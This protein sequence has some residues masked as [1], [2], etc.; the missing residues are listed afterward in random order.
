[1][2]EFISAI[3]FLNSNVVLFL[4]ISAIL[5]KKDKHI[6][7]YFLYVFSIASAIWSLGFAAFYVQTDPAQ[8]HVWRCFATFGTVLYVIV[9]QCL[10]A[11]ISRIQRKIRYIFDTIAFLG[12]P[13][14]L[15]SIRREQTSYFVS[16]FGMTYMFKP[17]LISN[18][19]FSYFAVVSLN[20]LITIVYM[21]RCSKGKRIKQF[22][23]HFLIVT[24]L[25]LVGT[26]L[27]MVLPV[28]G[29]GALPGSNITQ[30]WGIGVVYYAMNIIDKNEINVSNMSKYIYHSLGHPVMVFDAESRLQISNESADAFFDLNEEDKRNHVYCLGDLFSMEESF[31]GLTN[32]STLSVDAYTKTT[33]NPCNLT[34]S[35]IRDSY[36]DEIGYIVTVQDTSERMEYIESLKK[37]REEADS[38][39]QAKSRFLANMSHEIRT[40]MNAI[41]GFSEILLNQDMNP[42]QRERVGNIRNASRS[43]LAVIN[44]ILDISKIEAGRMELNEEDY[45]LRELI[46]DIVKQMQSLADNKGLEMEL[47]LADD[48]P[49]VVHGDHGKIREV[50]TN[51][52][53]NSIKYTN[54]GKVSLSVKA[55]ELEQNSQCHLMLQVEDTGI[56]V[57]EE[58]QELIFQAFEQSH[59]EK[60]IKT[61]GTG[62]G[63]SIVKG[64]IDLMGGT[65]ALKSQWGVGSVFTVELDQE[66][67]DDSNVG[68]E[69][70]NQLS[71]HQTSIGKLHIEGVQVL[72]VDDN[73][74]N[75]QVIRQSLEQY[76]LVVDTVSSGA[77]AIAK[78]REVQYPIIF[79]DQMMPE[80][81]GIQAMQAIRTLSAYYES[82]DSSKI[83]VLTANTIKGVREELLE[84][85]FDEYLKKPI[86]Y[87]HLEKT[88]CSFVPE[89]RITYIEIVEEDEKEEKQTDELRIPGVDVEEGLGHCGGKME[90][91]L[92]I[93]GLT[94]KNGYA[95]LAS[96]RERIPG[97]IDNYIIEI[98]GCK[99]MCYNIGAFSCGD[100]A[101]ELEMAAR[102]GQIDLILE[103]HPKFETLFTILLE[104]IASAI[105]ADDTS[106]DEDEETDFAYFVK[107]LKD[108]AQSYD[109]SKVERLVAKMAD[110]KW[111]GKEAEFLI[112]MKRL[113]DNV[114]FDGILYY[115]EKMENL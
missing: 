43:L 42:E 37:A 76:G 108:A 83:V 27:D 19:Y 56:G 87:K 95:Y 38:S 64:Y 89:D 105:G 97:D 75:L 81:D 84:K 47:N 17:G 44:Q 71:S 109:Y 20:L 107:S 110:N 80:M 93:L 70:L 69:V 52:L 24:I 55:T 74:I 1:M 31:M 113:S 22:G 13:V 16:R 30:F 3:L 50:L 35:S 28:L 5:R 4:M 104:Q 101:K 62:L 25:I 98:H 86:E 106:K 82:H 94:I 6:E 91:Y 100:K 18:L 39:N 114:D 32:D 61:E 23:R 15:L 78:C 85:G 54:T 49:V 8:A 60:R 59:E 57:K 10:I 68:E 41:M 45:N 58:E 14:Y 9:S 96:M 63:L 2:K 46:R 34:I 67:V 29:L 73:D 21:I 79:M 51:L 72:V 111:N 102:E 53:G 26:V 11:R 65:I 40:P 12:I 112:Q 33:K 77:Q 66:I 36:D 48:L 88:L 92:R 103:N 115:I 99:G 7:H 90:M